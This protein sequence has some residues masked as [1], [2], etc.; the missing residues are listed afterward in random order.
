MINLLTNADKISPLEV[1]RKVFIGTVYRPDTR[2]KRRI[3]KDIIWDSIY[4][5]MEHVS[6]YEPSVLVIVCDDGKKF[7]MYPEEE[8]NTTKEV[9]R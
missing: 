8:L 5:E 2:H 7:I 9:T 3:I 6:E 1:L 4:S